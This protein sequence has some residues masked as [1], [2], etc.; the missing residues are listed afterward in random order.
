MCD[1]TEPV[2]VSFSRGTPD[3]ASKVIKKVIRKPDNTLQTVL[4]R[5]DDAN[6]QCTGTKSKALLSCFFPPGEYAK[7]KAMA[8]DSTKIVH[9]H[10]TNAAAVVRAAWS[11]K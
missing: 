5:F 6:R 9:V 4:L 3:D 11:Q 1:A 10:G 8:I 7:V 2:L